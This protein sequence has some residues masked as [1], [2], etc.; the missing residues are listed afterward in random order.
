[1]TGCRT[2]RPRP[3][4]VTEWGWQNGF[5]RKAY[6]DGT[7]QL[8]QD[9]FSFPI[10]V[11]YIQRMQQADG[12]GL[13]RSDLIADWEWHPSPEYQVV[14]RAIRAEN[15]ILCFRSLPRVP[16]DLSCGVILYRA[17]G[18]RNFSPRDVALTHEL[19][20][21]IA[22]LV[23]GPLALFGEPSPAE[24]PPRCRQVLKC[25]LEGDGDKQIAARLGLKPYTVN[26]Y[27]KRIFVHFGV[28]SRTELLARWV[29]RGWGS[30]GPAWAD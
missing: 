6:L 16:G 15:M 13:R 11:R 4:G 5:D 8:K 17:T 12:V 3:L 30:A 2:G 21:L 20:A 1:M 18:E 7:D 19:N 23:G 26:D 14:F 10:L 29:R 22:P 27:T 25:L 28:I 9:P 24:L